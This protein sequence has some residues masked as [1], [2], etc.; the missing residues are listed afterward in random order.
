MKACNP[1]PRRCGTCDVRLANVDAEHEERCGR[2]ANGWQPFQ[3]EP[4]EEEAGDEG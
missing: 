3:D 1:E 4:I 2:E